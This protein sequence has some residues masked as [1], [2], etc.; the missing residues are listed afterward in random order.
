VV[1]L[2][3]QCV[4]G[5]LTSRPAV[6]SLS[7]STRS[8]SSSSSSVR[9]EAAAPAA[10]ATATATGTCGSFDYSPKELSVDDAVTILYR[11][12][13]AFFREEQH[14]LCYC[15]GYNGWDGDES[16]VMVP[17]LKQADGS[18]K[19]SII[20][21]NFAKVSPNRLVLTRAPPTLMHDGT[22]AS[23]TVPCRRDA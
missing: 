17:L 23:Q 3:S 13:S 14:G 1:A 20:I 10:A 21:P 8:R 2:Q 5:F 22:N 16:P 19:A 18:Y 11:P 6:T 12:P 9:L 4:H 7:R 15:G